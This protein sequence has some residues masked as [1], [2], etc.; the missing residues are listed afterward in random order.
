MKHGSDQ[1][2]M[3][4]VDEQKNNFKIT[5]RDWQ[6]IFLYSDKLSIII[7]IRHF[8]NQFLT[9]QQIIKTISKVTLQGG[10][11]VPINCFEIKEEYKQKLINSWKMLCNYQVYI[12]GRNYFTGF[13]SLSTCYSKIPQTGWLIN[14]RDLFLMVLEPGK[15]LNQIQDIQCLICNDILVHRTSYMADRTALQASFC[16]DTLT[17]VKKAPNSLSQCPVSQEH[18]LKHGYFNI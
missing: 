12:K 6:Y 18:H 15:S 17:S 3:S 2:L 9:T 10:E 8:T 7:R 11:N 5:K 4:K 1:H 13:S 14:N 16:M